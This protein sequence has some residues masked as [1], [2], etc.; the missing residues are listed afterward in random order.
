MVLAL[1]VHLF[2]LVE[3]WVFS[4]ACVCYALNGKLSFFTHF[5][6]CTHFLH[7]FYFL[8]HFFYSCA[9]KIFTMKT[10]KQKN[11]KYTWALTL[12]TLKLFY[13]HQIRYQ[14]HFTLSFGAKPNLI[15][16]WFPLYQFCPTFWMSST[17]LGD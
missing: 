7:L 1:F 13:G 9:F 15:P 16:H 2:A 4:C 11:F 10:R 6:S 3:Q 5:F 12:L 8:T 17:K 14:I